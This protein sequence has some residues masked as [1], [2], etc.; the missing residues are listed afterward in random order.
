MSLELSVI[1][2][3][4]EFSGASVSSIDLNTLINEDLGIDGD[5]GAEFLEEFAKR[6]SVDLATCSKTY[7]GPEG[8]AP[9]LLLYPIRAFLGGF[10]GWSEQIPLEP[11]P[12]QTLVESA[13]VGA[14]SDI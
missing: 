1:E 5:D 8:F 10:F 2:F 11:L 6:F 13:E 4:A 14:W 7:F 9:T 12:V 3:V